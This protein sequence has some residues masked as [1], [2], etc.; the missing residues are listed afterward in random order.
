M[1]KVNIHLL[2][3]DEHGPI[4][5][6]GIDNGPVQPGGGRFSVACSPQSRLPKYATGEARAA[7]CP[8][9]LATAAWAQKNHEE[10]AGASGLQP[11]PPEDFPESSPLRNCGCNEP[12][13]AAEP[14]P[15][16]SATALPAPPA[17]DSDL[18][19]P[20]GVTSDVQ[21]EST[22]EQPGTGGKG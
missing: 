1:S 10:T 13:P 2:V 21:P 18:G 4:Q 12:E 7:T 8:D 3:P 16:T 22:N 5:S 19:I 20:A 14:E 6:R 17:P 9:C 15:E 11:A